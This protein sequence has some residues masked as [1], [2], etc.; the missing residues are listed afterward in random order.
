MP[1]FDDAVIP[2]LLGAL[3]MLILCVMALD[4]IGKMDIAKKRRERDK[5]EYL[6]N[7]EN[8]GPDDE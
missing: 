8:K 3:A 7:L 1:P 2:F 6:R 4:A 5:R